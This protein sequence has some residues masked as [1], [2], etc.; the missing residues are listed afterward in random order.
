MKENMRIILHVLINVSLEK[1]TE[2]YAKTSNSFFLSFFL[3]FF[4]DLRVL[5]IRFLS[6]RSHG[7][8]SFLY[9][10][11]ANGDCSDTDLIGAVTSTRDSKFMRPFPVSFDHKI[12]VSC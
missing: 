3:S 12:S 5:E 11:Q 7:D 8:A 6:F 2:E 1:P 9:N 10:C 4:F